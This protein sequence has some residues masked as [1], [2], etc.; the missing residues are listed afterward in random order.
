LPERQERARLV[1]LARAKGVRAMALSWMSTM[2]HPSRLE[3]AALVESIAR[4]FERKTPAIF[5]AQ[6]KAL[7][8]RAEVFRLLANIR[9]PVL[10]LSGRSDRLSLPEANREM[11][12]AIP[13]SRLVILEEC[14]HMAPQERPLEVNRHLS[15]WLEQG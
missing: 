3:D 6:I 10:V 4:M 11:A 12:E 1:D 9:C 15:A 5:A 8:N 7:L 13:G 14:G 2:L